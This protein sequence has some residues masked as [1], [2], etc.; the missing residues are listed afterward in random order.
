ML[1]VWY[2]TFI[3][4]L[5]Y[6]VRLYYLKL[7]SL[8]SLTNLWGKS[9]FQCGGGHNLIYF[10][11]RACSAATNCLEFK[12]FENHA[13]EFCSLSCFFKSLLTIVKEEKVY[14]SAKCSLRNA[15]C[16]MCY[17]ALV[18]IVQFEI[19]QIH[20]RVLLWLQLGS[21][22]SVTNKYIRDMITVLI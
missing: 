22:V 6:F 9:N 3:A 19:I 21:T 8:T 5:N 16:Y 2:D 13:I 10:V 4:Q 15:M 7:C 17:K 1:Y 11:L 18:W 20:M 12:P 14:S